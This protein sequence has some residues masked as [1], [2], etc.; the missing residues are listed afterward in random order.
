MPGR[1]WLL[2]TRG[3]SFLGALL[4]CMILLHHFGC[5]C[6]KLRVNVGGGIVFACDVPLGVLGVSSRVVLHLC[7]PCSCVWLCRS[8]SVV[9]GNKRRAHDVDGIGFVVRY[10]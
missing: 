3:A 2:V 4:V 8:P 6:E 9:G 7:L 1:D 10:P 5:R